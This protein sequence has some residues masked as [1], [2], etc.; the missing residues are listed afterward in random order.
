MTGV[1]GLC[2]GTV[3]LDVV[4]GTSPYSRT[5]ELSISSRDGIGRLVRRT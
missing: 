3:K 4:P 2:V 5:G 1:G